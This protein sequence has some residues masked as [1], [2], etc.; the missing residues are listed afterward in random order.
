MCAKTLG[1]RRVAPIVAALALT[2][3]AVAGCGSSGSSGSPEQ[4]IRTFLSAAAAG[5]GATACAQLSAQAKA[6][7][8]QGTSCEQGIKLGSALYGS[9]IKQI[10][11]T[12]LKTEGST[13]SGTATLNG[14]ATATFRLSKSGGKWL[15]VGEQRTGTSGSTGS[16]GATGSARPSETRVTAVAH[17]LEKTFGLVDNFGSDTTGGVPHVVLGVNIARRSAAVI[18]VFASPSVATSG[19]PGIKTHEA[20]LTTKLDGGLVIVYFKPLPADKQ[21]SIEACS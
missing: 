6:Q 2:A 12:G 1:H 9:T 11:I 10:K 5:D 3:V 14:Q 8:V 17:C 15:I 18:N 19:Y 7:V 21:R 13:A 4:T 16:P 20:P